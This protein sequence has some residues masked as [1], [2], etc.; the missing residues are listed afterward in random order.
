MK[1]VSQ[2]TLFVKHFPNRIPVAEYFGQVNSRGLRAWSVP[3]LQTPGTRVGKPGLGVEKPELAGLSPH[4]EGQMLT[5]QLAFAAGHPLL[6]G[7]LQ[8]TE[9]L[10]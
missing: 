1:I 8:G 3:A 4:E 2:D 9:L 6:P 10:H 5:R 7:R